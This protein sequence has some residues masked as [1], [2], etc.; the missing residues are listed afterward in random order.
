M[1]SLINRMQYE[2]ECTVTL[3]GSDDYQFIHVEQ[4]GYVTSYAPRLSSGDYNHYMW[5]RPETWFE[6][7]IPVAPKLQSGVLEINVELS[8]QVRTNS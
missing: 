7:R 3:K 5:L 8:S 4:Y 6:V 1:C 2:L